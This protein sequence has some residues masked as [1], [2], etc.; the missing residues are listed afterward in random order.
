MLL[1]AAKRIQPLSLD[2]TGV[3]D[4]LLKKGV[5][6]SE[7]ILERIQEQGFQGA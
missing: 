7:V 6:N 1:Q 5:S 4:D 3:I 2:N